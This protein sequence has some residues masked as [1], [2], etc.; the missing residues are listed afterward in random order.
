MTMLKAS[1]TQTHTHNPCPVCRQGNE[2]LWLINR[3]ICRP[4]CS[5]LLSFNKV[6]LCYCYHRRENM[7]KM[8]KAPQTQNGADKSLQL[9]LRCVLWLPCKYMRVSVCLHV[10]LLALLFSQ[11]CLGRL[12]GAS[13]RKLAKRLAQLWIQQMALHLKSILP[14]GPQFL[15]ILVKR[16]TASASQHLCVCVCSSV[17]SPI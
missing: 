4:F 17:L 10:K 8:C 6:L 7:K 16:V 12:A 14:F 2:Q 3:L 1:L 9:L 13:D 11:V 15:S 5:V